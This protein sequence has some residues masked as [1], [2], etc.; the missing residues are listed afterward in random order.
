MYASKLE[1]G[2]QRALDK[3]VAKVGRE[4]A[5]Q[6]LGTGENT[7]IRLEGGGQARADA[8]QRVTQALAALGW[9]T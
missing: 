1:P 7:L 2:A 3:L 9:T 5:A 8:V 6:M 4:R